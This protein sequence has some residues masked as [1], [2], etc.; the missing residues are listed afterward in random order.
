MPTLADVGKLAGVSRGTVS[1]V[2]NHPELVRP[3]VRARVETAARELGYDGPDPRGRVL[4]DG[5]VNAIGIVPPGNWGVVDAMRNP[6][7]REFMLGVAEVCDAAGASLVITQDKGGNGGVRT[8]LVD[9]FIFG[10]IEHLADVEPAR[11]RRLPFAVIDVDAG[12][13][14]NSV[15][16]DAQ[17]GSLAAA[18]HLIG[19]GHRRF[20][21]VSFLRDFGPPR[22]HPPGRPRNADAAGMPIDQEKL[23]GYAEALAE[24][25]ISIDDVPIVQAHPWEREAAKLMLDVAP[26]AT[27]ILSMS[28]MQGIAVVAEARRR[29]RSVPR[30]LSVVG[31]NDIPE[32]AEADPPLTTVDGMG[33]EKGRVAAR[34]VLDGDLPRNEVL[35]ARLLLRGSTAPPAA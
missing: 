1:N 3:D 19:L 23:R 25:G 30:D 16:V 9:G 20:G 17:A 15:R 27:A 11:L 12:P 5:K 10:R 28:A 31:F 7:F 4:R 26:E 24:A 32:A 34:M 33:M 22:F 21:I 14:M 18:R 6:V 35:P 29:G 13:E 2:F 8:A